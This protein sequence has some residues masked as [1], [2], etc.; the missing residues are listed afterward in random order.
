MS[1]PETVTGCSGRYSPSVPAHQ[2]WA[3]ASPPTTAACLPPRQLG[4]PEPQRQGRQQSHAPAL[5]C[6][7]D[8]FAAV[9]R[10]VRVSE[11]PH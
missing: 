6:L 3:A 2:T 9:T 5:S 11:N 8:I 4:T 1:K 10:C 7:C